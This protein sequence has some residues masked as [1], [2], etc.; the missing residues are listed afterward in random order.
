MALGKP[1]EYGHGSLR[2]TLG[3]ANTKK[4]IDYVMK[5]LPGIIKKLRNIS[6]TW[7]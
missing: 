6:A 3:R 2:F 5:I 7:E 4:D 1:H